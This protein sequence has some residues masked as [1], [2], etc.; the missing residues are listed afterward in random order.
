MD[1]NP[2]VDDGARLPQLTRDAQR[3]VPH[4]PVPARACAAVPPAL[5]RGVSVPPSS[6]RL[7]ERMPE[8]GG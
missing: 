2:L 6:A 4:W 3:M 1:M 7:L 5:I 8:Y